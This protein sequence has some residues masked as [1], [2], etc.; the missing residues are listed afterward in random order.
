MIT[1]LNGKFVPEELAVVP[2]LDRGFLYGDG[3]F[4]TI[5]IHNGQ[6]FCWR[7]HRQRLEQGA[8]FLKIKLPYS[9]P[10]MLALAME[11]IAKNKMPDAILRL[12]LSRGPGA[13]GY[14]PRGAT[15][16]TFA[17][18]LHRAPKSTAT[19]GWKLITSSFRLPASDPLAR[20]KTANKLTQ[21][22]ARAE[23]DAAGADEAL[24]LNSD[25]FVAEGTSGNLFWIRNEIVFT[26]PIAAGILPGVTRALARR[27]CH[28]LKVPIVE[29]NIHLKDIKKADAVFLSL[30]SLGIVEAK[31]L[32]GKKLKRSPLTGQIRAA[33]L[34]MLAR[35]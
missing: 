2:V 13:R 31:W 5:R 6:P 20:F 8:K 22:L 32:D 11:L 7:E 12:A 35:G 27:I 29:K 26:P 3:L 16:P 28:Q 23:A 30:T 24:L 4:E 25:G 33:C 10:K 21:I 17:M 9:Q 1:F 34:Q 19:S 18:T 15:H 14:S